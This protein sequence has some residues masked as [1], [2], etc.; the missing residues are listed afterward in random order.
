MTT[1]I[2]LP[3]NSKIGAPVTIETKARTP[4]AAPSHADVPHGDAGIS[5]APQVSAFSLSWQIAWISF[6]VSCIAILALFRGTTTTLATL[7]VENAT[8]NH[9]FLIFPI[10]GYLIWLRRDS[11][12]RLQ[13]RPWPP[14]LILIAIGGRPIGKLF[15]VLTA[16]AV[17]WN[18]FGAVSFDRNQYSSYY[19]SARDVLYQP[20]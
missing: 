7:Y 19:F 18:A 11:L 9:G 16:W 12:K 15:Y 3:K 1:E 4:R 10:V 2:E 17:V 14:A 13:P 8:Y 6:G 20:D 5:S